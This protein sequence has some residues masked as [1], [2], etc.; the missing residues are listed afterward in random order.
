[1]KTKRKSFFGR[2]GKKKIKFNR[3]F[4]VLYVI[5]GVE[6]EPAD[7]ISDTSAGQLK[8]GLRYWVWL[9]TTPDNRSGENGRKKGE[10]YTHAPTHINTRRETLFSVCVC[11]C[12]FFILFFFYL[13]FLSAG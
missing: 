9:S 1:V 2:D 7:T 5:R 13:F 12:A 4:Y 8:A 6:R 11:V 3:S 10:H